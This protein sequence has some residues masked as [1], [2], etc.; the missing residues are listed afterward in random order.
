M[1]YINWTFNPRRAVNPGRKVEIMKKWYC[2]TNKSGE[3]AIIIDEDNGRTIAVAYDA[4]DGPLLAAA[5]EMLALL[6]RALPWMT[7]IKA[8]QLHENTVA[9]S[10]FERTYRDMTD[11]LNRH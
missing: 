1:V 6:Q 5:P 2:S 3:Q 8:D 4:G 9:P 7:K 11:F 10:V